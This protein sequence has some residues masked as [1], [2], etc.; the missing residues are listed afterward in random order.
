MASPPQVL[1]LKVLVPNR[2]P[3]RSK[4]SP[5]GRRELRE[6][7]SPP[8]AS[9]KSAYQAPRATAPSSEQADVSEAY[10]DDVSGERPR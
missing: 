3:Q 9:P 5:P 8:L 4:K 6:D 10:P 1:A 7:L 2:I